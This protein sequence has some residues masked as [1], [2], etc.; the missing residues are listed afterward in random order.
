MEKKYVFTIRFGNKEFKASV[1]ANSLE[2]AKEKLNKAMKIECTNV[3]P[4]DSFKN[5]DIERL[6]NIFGMK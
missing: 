2:E 5:D 4:I 6:K 1:L 3:E